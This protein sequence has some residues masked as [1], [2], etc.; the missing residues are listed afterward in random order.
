MAGSSAPGVYLALAVLVPALAA[1]LVG[2]QAATSSAQ[3]VQTQPVKTLASK[4]FLV[5]ES[6]AFRSPSGTFAGCK[7]LV[8][9]ASEGSEARKLETSAQL[10]Q[11]QPVKTLEPPNTHGL[12]G[13]LKVMRSNLHAHS[14][15]YFSEKSRSEARKLETS[16]VKSVRNI[17]PSGQMGEIHKSAGSGLCFMLF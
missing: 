7:F 15:D 4:H 11:T 12:W 3:L 5:S 17:Q 13:L 10:V 2:G 8:L 16:E 9:V 6:Y 14:N 1:D